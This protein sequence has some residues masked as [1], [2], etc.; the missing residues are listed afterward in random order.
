MRR[1]VGILIL[2]GIYAT[3]YSKMRDWSPRRPNRQLF[4]LLLPVV[5][6]AIAAA[7]TCFAVAFVPQRC[8]SSTRSREPINLQYQQK[9]ELMMAR[10]PPSTDSESDTTEKRKAILETFE[11]RSIQ[12]GSSSKVRQYLYKTN[13][14][15]I[16]LEQIQS[17]LSYLDS[18][19]GSAELTN[20]VLQSTPRIMRK[21]VDTQLKPT[22][23]FL[24][25]IYSDDLF[26][27]A[28]ERN[29]RLLVTSGVGYNGSK[30]NAGGEDVEKYLTTELGLAESAVR[31][32]KKSNPTV[33]QFSVEEQIR[34]VIDYVVFLF[35][36]TT[37]REI[38]QVQVASA[39]KAAGKVVRTCPA[40]LG[41]SV[42]SNLMPKI[43]FLR[44]RCG[45]DQKDVAK[46]IESY[47][48][49]LGLSLS[50]NIQPTIDY[51]SNV[52]LDCS[53][54]CLPDDAVE[55]DFA[56]WLED[57]KGPL[58]KC[59]SRHP[60]I[61]GL[62][63]EN[64]RSKV[65]Y[66][67]K[68]DSIISV[69][70]ALAVM[71]EGGSKGQAEKKES[72]NKRV[73]V[74]SLAA[75]VLSAAPSAYSLSLENNIVP[76]TECFAKLWGTNISAGSDLDGI[77]TI[78]RDENGCRLRPLLPKS[79]ILSSLLSE[80][81]PVLTLSTEGNLLPTVDFY[82]RTGYVHLDQEGRAIS[83]QKHDEENN[84]DRSGTSAIRARYL[85]TSL[86]NRLLPRWHYYKAQRPDSG[87]TSLVDDPLCSSIDNGGNNVDATSDANNCQNEAK[88][89]RRPPLHLL[90][91]ASDAQFCAKCSFDLGSYEQY[92]EDEAGRLKFSWQFAD[93]V[94]TG[95]RID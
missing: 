6:G 91:G 50:L 19:L 37:G 88:A 48:E 12:A 41:L 5:V 20:A 76:K 18:V 26:L 74:Q 71:T 58:R 89:S 17:V 82:N 25:S 93:W 63:T 1:T 64:L 69:D 65:A 4:V 24:Q 16:T 35:V 92:R 9:T 94:K 84:G 54:E 87:E 56:L 27:K 44:A 62:S 83:L 32:L 68:I 8:F 31:R 34:P 86:F 70:A 60:Q 2:P 75:R 30:R 3:R 66:F 95:R 15:T 39:Q 36:A 21:V 29:P 85:A 14:S 61:F 57:A 46:I 13:L 51:L 52:L 81:P 77:E 53:A 38:T 72:D 80:Y 73:K 11:A 22:V 42:A 59:L 10:Q 49:V 90:A 55:E 28:I 43:D 45:L 47:P 33:F 78:I 23:E 7:S 67:D 40:V 79:N